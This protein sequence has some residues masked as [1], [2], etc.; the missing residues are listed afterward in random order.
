MDTES[1]IDKT[2][3]CRKIMLKDEKLEDIQVQLQIS[4]WKFLR[5]LSQD[6]RLC[7]LVVRVPGYRSRGPEFDSQHY[8]I[9][10][11]VVGL[12]W[13][14]FSLLSRTEERLGRNSNSSGVE[15]QEY[16]HKDPMC[17]PCNTLYPQKLTPTS[18]TSGGRSVDIVHSRTKAIEFTTRYKYVWRFC[19]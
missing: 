10:W 16:S 8:H 3:Y 11:E 4:P 5:Q 19:F 14:P 7:G 13:G 18:L 17:W 9:F 12:E 1:V 15:N 6:D 2:Q